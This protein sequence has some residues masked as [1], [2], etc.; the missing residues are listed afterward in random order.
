MERNKKESIYT[1]AETV[2]VT[3]MTYIGFVITFPFKF[4]K[5]YNP[6]CLYL[7]TDFS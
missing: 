7:N 6:F 2:F 5:P 3:F 1:T 4:I